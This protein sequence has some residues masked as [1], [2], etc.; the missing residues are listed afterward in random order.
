M[1]QGLEDL[2][3]CSAKGVRRVGAGQTDA[4]SRDDLPPGLVDLSEATDPWAKYLAPLS[5]I[6]RTPMSPALFPRMHR[7]VPH[8]HAPT[9]TRAAATS[10]LEVDAVSKGPG[11]WLRRPPGP[12]A[13]KPLRM[14]ERQTH[15]LA[16]I[17][18]ESCA[19]KHPRLREVLGAKW[20]RRRSRR[21]VTPTDPG[22]MS[23]VQV[24]GRAPLVWAIG[25]GRRLRDGAPPPPDM[26]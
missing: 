1:P 14:E 13:G 9:P 3:L 19:Y 16:G 26:P 10:M 25:E 18:Q 6:P 4:S 7:P 8:T 24:G 20:V 21:R 17:G 15:E 22:R 5:G 12:V 11:R 2:E 23:G